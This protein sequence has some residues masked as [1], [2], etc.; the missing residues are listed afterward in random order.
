VH[1]D[2]R[3]VACH[4]GERRRETGGAAVLQRLDQPALDE[5]ERGLDQ[6]LAGEG[7]ADLNRRTLVRVVL[8]ELRAG[9]H[10]CAADPVAA[11]R[12]AVED[13]VRA[14]R[15][16]ARARNSARGEEPDAHCVHEAV[17][18]VGL[19]EDRLA[20]DGRHAH[21]VSVCAD[22]GDGAVEVV[23]GL[24]E[25]QPVEDRDR[26][27]TH[28]DD[29]A[30]D[31]SDSGC[32]SLER[33]DRGGMVVRLDLERHGL[34]VPDVDHAGV[35]TGALQDPFSLRGKPLEQEGRVLVA[36]VLRPE[37]R[38]HRQLEVVRVAAEQLPDAVE[39]LV[40]QPQ[41]A[42]ERLFRRDLRQGSES[43]RGRRRVPATFPLL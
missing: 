28:R 17:V 27:R 20:A 21:A 31:P 38:E 5:L 43:T 33:L 2:A 14:D 6:L 35:L 9:E 34:A 10:R 1:V 30:Q 19:V 24:G 13:D 23:V 7:I 4:L 16:R 36:A 8:A 25:A 18:P 15:R 42:V 11:G 29:V 32:R 22:A 26:P 3:A 41:G 39:L 12:R 40:G 37:E